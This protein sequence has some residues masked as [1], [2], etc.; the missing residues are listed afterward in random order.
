MA[1]CGGLQLYYYLLRRL[2]S[3][4]LKFKANW[5]QKMFLRRAGGVAQLVKHF[6]HKCK[7]HIPV[8][9]PKKPQNPKKQK[10]SQDP[11]STN[12]SWR[13]LGSANRRI[14]AKANPRHK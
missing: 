7:V 9:P 3:G 6:P 11:I 8:P 10:P 13:W 12:R 1:G 14:T 2:T 5:G 4:G